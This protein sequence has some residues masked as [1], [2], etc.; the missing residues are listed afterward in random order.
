MGNKNKR[1]RRAATVLAALGALVMSSGIALMVTATPANATHVENHDPKVVVCKYVSTPGGVLHHIV[2]VS[3]STLSQVEEYVAPADG[4]QWTD[5]QGQEGGSI[6]IRYAGEGPPP[7][8]ADTI[9]ESECPQEG[10]GGL[11]ATATAT[12]IQ[13]TCENGNIADYTTGGSNV[14]F[15]ESAAPAPDTNIIVTATATGGAE[16]EEGDPTTKT[17]PL[18]FNP[19]EAGC[20]RIIVEGPQLDDPKV[21]VSPPGAD[22]AVTPTVVSAGLTDVGPDLRGEQGLALVFAGMLMLLGA[23][24]LGLRLRGG[25]SRG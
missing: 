19:A 18:A 3:E 6:A 24:G 1:T 21:E 14:T 15:E 25:G 22:P 9:S 4:D 11:I 10:G 12:A 23:G 5:A 13:P 17:F 7:E 16:F 20:G 8:Q 2:V